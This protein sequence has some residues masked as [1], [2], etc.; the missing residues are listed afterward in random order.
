M[1]ATVFCFSSEL[2]LEEEDKCSHRLK[3]SPYYDS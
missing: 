2:Q 3:Y 1:V